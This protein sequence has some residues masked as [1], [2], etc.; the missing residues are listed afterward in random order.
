MIIFKDDD[1]GY[2]NWIR[3]NHNGFVVNCMPTS[4]G[5]KLT[6]H[7]ARC[8]TITKH[9]KS[10][11]TTHGHTKTCSNDKEELVKWTAESFGRKPF[12]CE[13]CRPPS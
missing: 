3:D 12:P 13:V 5:E 7:R 10:S 2:L 4:F 11:T 9:H 6:L 8:H 1:I